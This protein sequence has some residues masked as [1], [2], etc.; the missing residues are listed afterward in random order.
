[1]GQGCIKTHY[2]NMPPSPVQPSA[3]SLAARQTGFDGAESYVLQWLELQW[4]EAG[5]AGQSPELK[6]WLAFSAWR[7]SARSRSAPR[8]QRTA[9]EPGAATVTRDTFGGGANRLEFPYDHGQRQVSLFRVRYDRE[10]VHLREILYVLPS[11]ARRAAL[12]RRPVLLSILPR[13]RR[14]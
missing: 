13:G 5:W 8:V 2:P 7:S 11:A 1:M 10:R 12:R 9:G 4:L 6:R 3:S 14:L